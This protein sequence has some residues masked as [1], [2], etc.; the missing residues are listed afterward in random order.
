MTRA[1]FPA[2]AL[3]SG[4]EDRGGGGANSSDSLFSRF[5]TSAIMLTVTELLDISFKS[6]CGSL[7]RQLFPSDT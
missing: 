3:L 4:M 1:L 6:R 7:R 2:Y 5:F